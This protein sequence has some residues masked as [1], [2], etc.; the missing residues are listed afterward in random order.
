MIYSPAARLSNPADLHDP[1][2]FV[3]GHVIKKK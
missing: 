1:P 2:A 3:T